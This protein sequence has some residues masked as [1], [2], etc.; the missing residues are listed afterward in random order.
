[1]NTGDFVERNGRTW[2]VALLANI[3]NGRVEGLDGGE[4]AFLVHQNADRELIYCL[5][6][7]ASIA[8]DWQGTTVFDTLDQAVINERDMMVLRDTGATITCQGVDGRLK[9]FLRWVV[10]LAQH[11]GSL[12]PRPSARPATEGEW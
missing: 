2:V 10:A 3:P 5:Q 12:A 1:M 4:Y 7:I 9:H 8:N 11:T 6:P